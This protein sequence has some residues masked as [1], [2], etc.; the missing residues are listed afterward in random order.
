MAGDFQALVFNY[1]IRFLTH[2]H[3]HTHSQLQRT[4]R[5][6]QPYRKPPRKLFKKT[7]AHSCTQHNN[8]QNQTKMAAH[9]SS[10]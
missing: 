4:N 2:T 5:Y 10:V 9:Y 1:P 6:W 7:H 8:I 3:T